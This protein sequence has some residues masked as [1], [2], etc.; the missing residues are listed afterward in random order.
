M[1][2]RNAFS[3]EE[4]ISLYGCHKATLLKV[5]TKAGVKPTAVV[6]VFGAAVEHRWLA[7]EVAPAWRAHLKA[8][9]PGGRKRVKSPRSKMQSKALTRAGR[10]E[11]ERAKI[12]ARLGLTK[13]D[14]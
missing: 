7:V 2:P 8:R 10:L 12:L 4:I 1:M 3:T 6:P 14:R 9:K 13:P 11:V 5:L